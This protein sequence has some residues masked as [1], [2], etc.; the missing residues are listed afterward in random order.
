MRVSLCPELVKEKG[1]VKQVDTTGALKKRRK[2]GAEAGLPEPFAGWFASRSWHPHAH[3][4]QLL[5]LSRAPPHAA[6]CANRRRQD[7]CRLPAEPGRSQ[8]A[9]SQAAS[10][11]PHPLR[12]AVEG[13]CRRYRPQFDR[14]GGRDGPA[15]HARDP[16]RRYAALTPPAPAPFPAKH[17]LTTPE[18]IALM[19]SHRDAGSLFGSLR[20][21][22]IDE[23]H[24]PASTKRGDLLALDLRACARCRRISPP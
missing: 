8:W 13:A 21:V 11:H 3:Q 23:L 4:L 18:Q 16:H 7:A 22:I 9:R 2:E 12:L 10:R 17:P 14:A 6:D 15:D 24:A 5:D 19:L 20:T 1:K